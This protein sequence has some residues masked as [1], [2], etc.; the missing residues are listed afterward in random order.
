MTGA[1]MQLDK[2]LPHF[3][4]NVAS[5]L[6]LTGKG[7]IAEGMDADLLVLSSEL[8]VQHLMVAGRWHIKDGAMQILG[9][10]EA[11]QFK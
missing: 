8:Q 6:R 1:G 2:A 11:E 7:I 10:F 5:L 3:T 9:S 4:S